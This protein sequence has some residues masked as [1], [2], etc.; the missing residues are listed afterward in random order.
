M[1][2]SEFLRTL[3]DT[4]M[5]GVSAFSSS[6]VLEAA[7]KQIQDA[8][9]WLEAAVRSWKERHNTLSIISRLPPEILSTIFRYVADSFRYA[10]RME[11]IQISHV[12]THWRRVALE[13]RSLWTNIASSYPKW[14]KEI[15][16]RSQETPLTVLIDVSDSKYDSRRRHLVQNILENMP[17][18][19]KLSFY[20]NHGY[21]DVL[22]TILQDF[23]LPAPLLERLKLSMK[24]MKPHALPRDVFSGQTPRLRQLVLRN[25]NLVWASPFLH[26]LTVLKVDSVV[27]TA[28][29]SMREAINALRNMPNLRVLDLRHAL[30]ALVDAASE[31]D[32]E[33]TVLLTHLTQVRLESDMPECIYFLSHLTYPPTVSIKLVCVVRSRSADSLDFSHTIHR[34]GAILSA[35]Q[36]IRYIAAQYLTEPEAIRLTTSDIPGIIISQQRTYRPQIDLTLSGALYVPGETTRDNAWEKMFRALWAAIPMKDLETLRV[37]QK[38]AFQDI[39]SN[40]FEYLTAA[41]NLKRLHVTEDSGTSFLRALFRVSQV[42]Q[43]TER[44]FLQISSLQELAIEGWRFN[45]S[46]DGIMCLELLR[47]CLEDRLK[48]NA[49]VTQLSFKHCQHLCDDD[50]EKLKGAVRNVIWF[51][52]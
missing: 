45:E 10:Y 28:R 37:V 9:N 17:R 3:P 30:P 50:I 40:I 15:L 7:Y 49:A 39:W 24:D 5:I 41:T 46:V 14:A 1:K 31:S 44:D 38:S 51:T 35:F 23:V 13:C 8:I 19:R 36:P 16:Q 12:C 11:W 22:E 18:I 4:G 20:H 42:G 21:E 33:P 6:R 47:I 25:C 29:P 48:H 27:H 26:N 32:S 34:L 52:S 43:S 2:E